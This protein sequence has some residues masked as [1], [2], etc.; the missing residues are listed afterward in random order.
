MLG[1]DALLTLAREQHR[2]FEHGRIDRKWLESRIDH[3]DQT[4]YLCGPPKMVEGL[5]KVLK[6]LGANTDSVIFEK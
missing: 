4:F 3:F 2:D 1:A 5:T 6:S